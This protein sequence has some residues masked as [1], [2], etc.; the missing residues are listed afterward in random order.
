VTLEPELARQSIC[1][2]ETTGRVSG[3]PRV[4]AIWFAADPVRDRIYLLAGGR[5][6]AHWVRNLRHDPAV[7]IRIGGHTF[8]G[9]AS[10]IEG[11]PDDGLAR[12]LLP[13]KYE[14]ADEPGALS[15]WAQ[16]ALPV[17]IDLGTP[18]D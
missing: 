6:R 13:G 18:V 4:I 1:Y 7:R 15:D 3:R 16:E 2:L 8:A 14:G 17:A 10:V 11:G 5:D 12:R 9:R